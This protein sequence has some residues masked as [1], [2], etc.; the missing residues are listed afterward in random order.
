MTQGGGNTDS[1]YDEGDNRYQFAKSLQEQHPD[2]VKI[3]K[4]C[5]RVHHVVNYKPFEKNKL[6]RKK[7]IKYEDM[8]KL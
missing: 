2:V 5:G 7:N 6:I 8:M 1:I 3:G 4:R